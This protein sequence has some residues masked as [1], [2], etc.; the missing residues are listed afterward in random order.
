MARAIAPLHSAALVSPSYS[1]VQPSI[2]YG[3]GLEPPPNQRTS[4]TG[5]P[6]AYDEDTA[7][8]LSL[9]SCLSNNSALGTVNICGN[10]TTGRSWRHADRVE[11]CNGTL[12]SDPEGG[13]PSAL[14]FSSTTRPSHASSS[15]DSNTLIPGMGAPPSGHGRT[16][17][18]PTTGRG[19]NS[20]PLSGSPV[21]GQ[22]TINP[23]AATPLTSTYKPTYHW[24]LDGDLSGVMTCARMSSKSTC[25]PINFNSTPSSSSDTEFG[26][27]LNSEGYAERPLPGGGKASER[28]PLP[29]GWRT[30]KFTLAANA[31]PNDSPINSASP[32]SIQNP[33]C[34]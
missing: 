24:P 4:Y 21:E 26:Y 5:Y 25:S 13:N 3:S 28:L 31:E 22:S 20:F 7:Y 1:M 2:E 33:G 9:S 6:V 10:S 32:H 18:N 23:A 11:S 19:N 15:I 27:V 34:C 14:N 30:P 12:Y 8:S 17:P 16:L 29:V